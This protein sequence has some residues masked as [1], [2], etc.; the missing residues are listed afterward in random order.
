[1][2]ERIVDR[3]KTVQV[4]DQKRATLMVPV[5]GNQRLFDQLVEQRSIGQAGEAVVVHQ[6][7]HALFGSAQDAD[8]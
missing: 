6:V 8:V 1:M 2:P 5:R 3:G 7:L 4:D